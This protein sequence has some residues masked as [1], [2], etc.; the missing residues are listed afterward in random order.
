MTKAEENREN[1]DTQYEYDCPS[2]KCGRMSCSS[3]DDEDFNTAMNYCSAKEPIVKFKEHSASAPRHTDI[4][5]VGVSSPDIRR[6]SIASITSYKTDSFNS[7]CRSLPDE[8]NGCRNSVH[9]YNDLKV[10]NHRVGSNFK[11]Q[12]NEESSPNRRRNSSIG[13]DAYIL[14]QSALRNSR[15]QSTMSTGSRASVHFSRHF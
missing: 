4:L 1:M 13:T 9:G 7:T 15:I 5:G 11:I 6:N 10:F 8:N 12:K 3:S 14:S 2:I